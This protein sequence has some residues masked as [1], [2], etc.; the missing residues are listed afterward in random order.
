MGPAFSI[1]S[2]PDS[3]QWVTNVLE[4]TVDGDLYRIERDDVDV[5]RL[6]LFVNGAFVGEIETSYVGETLETARFLDPSG[7]HWIKTDGDGNRIDQSPSVS[8][9][10][11]G[12]DPMFDPGCEF[13]WSGPGE[14]QTDSY[15]IMGGGCAHLC[16]AADILTW[17]AIGIGGAAIAVGRIPGLQKF[18]GALAAA[19]VVNAAAAAGA[20]AGCGIC[21][22]LS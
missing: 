8:G 4:M 3:V 10:G 1:S 5:T 11:G 19:F 16:E 18:G 21:N 15:S 6:T 17:S 2:Y 7:V 14:L 9:G 12:C 20:T 13:P 22:M